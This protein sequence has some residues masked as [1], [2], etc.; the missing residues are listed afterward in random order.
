MFIFVQTTAE[1][2]VIY[3]IQYKSQTF[4]FSTFKYIV[5]QQLFYFYSINIGNIDIVPALK[6]FTVKCD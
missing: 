2:T 3:S 4:K 6:D 5:E 1:M